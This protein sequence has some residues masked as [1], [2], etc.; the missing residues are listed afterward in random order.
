MKDKT[1]QVLVMTKPGQKRPAF[2]L[3]R[4]GL[5]PDTFYVVATFNSEGSCRAAMT[6]LNQAQTRTEMREL[7]KDL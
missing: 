2:F 4:R 5:E 7:N 6:A 3:A 1:F